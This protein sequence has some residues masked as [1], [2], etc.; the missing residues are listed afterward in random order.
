MEILLFLGG[1]L[2]GGG[3]TY[4]VTF[5]LPREKIREQNKLIEMQE[6]AAQNEFLANQKLYQERL[7]TLKSLIQSKED[8]L[9]S[10]QK[11]EA[12]MRIQSQQ[13]ADNY[14]KQC[15]LTAQEALDKQLE[16]IA[17]EYQKNEEEYKFE[18]LQL[19][20]ELALRYSQLLQDQQIA[21]DSKNQELAKLQK[22]IDV[23]VEAAKREEEKK[24]KIHFY[25]INLSQQDKDE[26]ARLRS[27]ASCLRDAEAL[28]KV[29]WKVYYENPTNDLIGRVVGNKIKTGIYKITNIENQM[30]YV[31]QSCDI[32]SRW[33]QH[34]KRGIGAEAP[35]RNKLYPAML[36]IGVEN[37]TFEIIEECSRAELD[38]REQYWQQFFKAK[39]FGYSIK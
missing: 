30:C 36:A 8:S 39:E 35:T 10:I 38:S 17:K 19:T 11:A 26:I 14:A 25:H 33:K 29:I 15:L 1:L 12:Q 37:F 9:S 27:V 34:I 24:Q 32:A 21:V 7:D 22:D 5:I 2:V 18:Y 28:N 16:K 31:G 20:E 13:N 23:A 3:I 6:I 4:V